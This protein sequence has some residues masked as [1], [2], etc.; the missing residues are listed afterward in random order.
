MEIKSFKRNENLQ[1]S[2]NGA[3]PTKYYRRLQGLI[4]LFSF[5]LSHIVKKYN[6]KWHITIRSANVQHFFRKFGRMSTFR[7]RIA[8]VIF[9]VHLYFFSSQKQATVF[10]LRNDLESI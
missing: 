3:L 5:I 2:R 9:K 8:D 4:L 10:I 7:Y 6:I 1:S